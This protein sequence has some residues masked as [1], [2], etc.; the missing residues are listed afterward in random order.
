M[1][2]RGLSPVI[3]TVLL[4]SL[5]VVL[6]LIILIWAKTWVSEKVS[7]FDEPID[8]AC[9]KLNI[10]VQVILDQGVTVLN[11]GNVPVYG[12]D[13]RKKSAGSLTNLGGTFLGTINSGQS[14]LIELAD[15][16]AELEEND[17][18]FVV[19]VII[20]ESGNEKVEYKCEDKA[21][22]ATVQSLSL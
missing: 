16:G 17:E 8:R 20:G 13:V 4:I 7:K 15:A 21:V 11:R 5:A 12:V 1:E 3:A 19:P 18:V 10:E 14:S 9:E 2:K 6:A 22:Q